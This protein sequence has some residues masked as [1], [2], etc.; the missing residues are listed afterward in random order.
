MS[1]FL[2]A[3]SQRAY[4]QPPVPAEKA[5]AAVQKSESREQEQA[6][7]ILMRMAEFLGSA[8]A[9]SVTMR[10]GYDTVQASGQKIEFGEIR[11]I[12]ASR[13]D[14]LRVESERSDGSKTLT[15]LTGKE[16]RLIDFADNVFATGAQ[17]GGLDDTVVHLVRDLHVRFPLAMLLLSRLPAEFN[18]RV[19]AIDYVE[20][21]NIQGIPSYHLA[22]RGD[23]VDFQVWVADGNQP[24]P[25]R[26]V[27]TYKNEPGQP[28]FWAQLSDWN[29]APKLADDTFSARVPDGATRIAFAAE[30]PTV[31]PGARKVSPAKGGKK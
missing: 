26:V 31:Q 10:C 3:I 17:P 8:Q 27:L 25:V 22:A 13:P 12:I 9:F 5:P 23:T 4:S 19:R 1:P 28:Q 30:I 29:F 11:K 16:I 7:T 15:V 21:T 2:W 14:R 6:R 24:V 20:K 18:E